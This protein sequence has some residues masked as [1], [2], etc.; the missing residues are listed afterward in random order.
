MA[1]TVMWEWINI[2]NTFKRSLSSIKSICQL[3]FL[4]RQVHDFSKYSLSH[5]IYLS[6][7]IYKSNLMKQHD[8]HDKRAT[9][10][11]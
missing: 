2:T 9:E 6:F 1:K 3:T 4:G 5:H 7:I 10:K 11:A 8:I